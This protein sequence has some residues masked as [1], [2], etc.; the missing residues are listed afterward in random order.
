MELKVK[1]GELPSNLI[2]YYLGGHL[3][4]VNSKEATKV[5][6]GDE[7]EVLIPPG[8]F[9]CHKARKIK[10]SSGRII[11]ISGLDYINNKINNL[12]P[13]VIATKYESTI[14]D[15]LNFDKNSLELRN[16]I[17]IIIGLL[18]IEQDSNKTSNTVIKTIEENSRNKDYS[19]DDLCKK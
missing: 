13:G 17:S 15:I 19:L 5:V 18:L 14:S 12:S 9:Y 2:D 11:I 1:N 4:L 6:L 3:F 16:K 10:I 8:T 7:K